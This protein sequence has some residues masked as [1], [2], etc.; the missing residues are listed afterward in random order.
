MNGVLLPGFARQHLQQL[1]SNQPG[2]HAADLVRQ[3][4]ALAMPGATFVTLT[5]HGALRGCIGTLQAHRSLAD[6]LLHNAVAAAL[7]DSRFSPVTADELPTLT[8][9][10]SVLTPPRDFPCQNPDE[11]V[12]RLQP[13]VHGVILHYKGRRATFLPQV[14]QQLPD[15]AHF[16]QNLCLKAGAPGDCW[17]QGARL[18]VYTVEK[19]H[20]RHG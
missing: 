12:Q 19:F 10:V 5:C 1:L 8:L 7:H 11:M 18:E 20:E 4:E 6:D 15:P 13:G 2:L 14:W 16:L 3:D 17:R 9:E